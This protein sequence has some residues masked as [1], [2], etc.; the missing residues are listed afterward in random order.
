MHSEQC[1]SY[2]FSLQITCNFNESGV[3]L[4]IYALEQAI[5]WSYAR[6]FE[7]NVDHTSN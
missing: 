6:L 5:T 7:L 2:S 4:Q 3:F 1:D